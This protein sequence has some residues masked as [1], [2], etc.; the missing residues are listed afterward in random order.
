MQGQMNAMIS[1]PV[2]GVAGTSQ[3][4]VL[5]SADAFSADKNSLPKA[6]FGYFQLY[7]PYIVSLFT[8]YC[9]KKALAIS[10]L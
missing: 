4:G 9:K 1:D 7:T 2:R 6:T 5:N 8:L 3:R 10:A